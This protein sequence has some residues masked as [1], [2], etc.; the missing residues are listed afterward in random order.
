[1]TWCAPWVIRFHRRFRLTSRLTAWFSVSKARSVHFTFDSEVL[2]EKDRS[3]VNGANE[4]GPKEKRAQKYHT[5]RQ[6]LVAKVKA[7][8][9]LIVTRRAKTP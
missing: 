2:L 7:Q 3:G 1:M 8:L 5:L 4:T 9:A 6:H